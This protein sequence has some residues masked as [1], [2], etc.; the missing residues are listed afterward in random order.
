MTSTNDRTTL[1]CLF[2]HDDQA[3]AALNE[4]YEAG[5]PQSS[6]S[7]IGGQ[8]SQGAGKSGTSELDTLDIPARDMEHLRDGIQSGGSIVAVSAISDEVGTVE[9]VFGRHDATKIDESAPRNTDAG[10]ASLAG[11]DASLAGNSGGA[12]QASSAAGETA[13]PIMEEELAVGKRTV[14]H[15]GVRVFRRV[16]EIPAEESINL[17]E[18]HVVVDRR[19][20]DRPATQTDLNA[21][22]ER[23]VELKETAE[24][25]VIT[26][27]A[28]VV[29]E[30][31]VAKEV[32]EHTQHIRET[33]RRTEVD[34]EELPPADVRSNAKK[35]F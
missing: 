25:A 13:I 11:N 20:V 14:D 16:V 34:I 1:V 19:A 10:R 12:A 4:L 8:T 9:R 3:R 30:V 33:V 24:E 29:E 21:Q 26:K 6:I 27:N 18:E 17:R 23:S 22:G 2:H 31:V 32:G 35:S 7:V 5:I 28:R 15:G